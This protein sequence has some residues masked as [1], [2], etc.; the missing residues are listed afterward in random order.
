MSSV[1]GATRN[2]GSSVVG[3]GGMSGTMGIDRLEHKIDGLSNELQGVK[4]MLAAM[5]PR[6]EVDSELGRRVSLEVY[7]SDQRATN[8]RLMR[9]ESSPAKLL[10]WLGAA[11]GCLGVLLAGGF[12]VLSVLGGLAL[13]VL[14]HYKP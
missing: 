4:I 1:R 9:L 5:M 12:G 2:L 11:T 10:A 7:T 8:E 3:G 13:F 14:T 6:A